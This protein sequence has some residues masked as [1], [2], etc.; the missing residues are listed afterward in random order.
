MQ[1]TRRETL[2]QV[3]FNRVWEIYREQFADASKFRMLLVGNINID[4]LRPLL[5]RYIASLPS[6]KNNTA[7]VTATNR[8]KYATP[9]VRN[10]DEL[11]LFKKHMNTPSTRCNTSSV[12]S[13]LDV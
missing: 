9:D 13:L 7:T 3:S 4:S 5:C 6:G 10:A 11:H 12:I 1:P 8:T 2:K